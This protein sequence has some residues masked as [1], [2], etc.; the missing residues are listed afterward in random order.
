M[1]EN[2]LGRTLREHRERAGL[3]VTDVANR[4]HID[5]MYLH[6]LEGQRADWL[7]RPLHGGPVRQPSRDLIIRLVVALQL[8]INEADELLMQSGYAPLSPKPLI[9]TLMLPE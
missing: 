1:A 4:V 7:N 9:D 8:D 3:T 6:K 2:V 5:R